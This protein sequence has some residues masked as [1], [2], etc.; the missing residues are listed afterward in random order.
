M[1][2][3]SKVPRGRQFEKE[4][5]SISGD[6]IIRRNSFRASLRANFR[7]QPQNWNPQKPPTKVGFSLYWHV[8]R[9]L[10]KRRRKDLEL[11]VSLQTGSDTHGLDGFF[12]LRSKRVTI[13]LATYEKRLFKADVLITE[14]DVM[15]RRVVPICCLV[16]KFFAGEINQGELRE[17]MRAM[18]TQWFTGSHRE[19]N[20]VA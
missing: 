15:R 13:D 20:N 6:N 17:Q 19:V 8:W 7:S 5:F 16:A 3:I 18:R 1:L 9:R 10:P 12:S 11:R 4:V 14:E 2:V